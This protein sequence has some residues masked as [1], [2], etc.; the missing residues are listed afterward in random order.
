MIVALEADDRFR[1]EDATVTGFIVVW[2]WAKPPRTIPG[3][4]FPFCHFSITLHFSVGLS[5][6]CCFLFFLHSYI[7]LFATSSSLSS[8]SAMWGGCGNLVTLWVAN[9]DSKWVSRACHNGWYFS[10][11]S[12]ILERLCAD[13]DR[14]DWVTDCGESH[15]GQRAQSYQ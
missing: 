1:A 12:W 5:G 10:I 13:T 2:V 14:E 4:G 15:F 7:S 6:S 9:W 8:F 3:L 11:T